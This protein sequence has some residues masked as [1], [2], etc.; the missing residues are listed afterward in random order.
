MKTFYVEVDTNDADYIGQLVEVSNEDAEKWMP[1][2]EKLKTSNHIVEFQNMEWSGNTI[3]TSHLVNAVEKI[4]V[5]N[6]RANYI[7]S[8]KRKWKHSRK[9]FGCGEVS[10]VSIQLHKSLR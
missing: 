2:I 10:M 6:L 9:H 8:A 3:T 7:I 1:L 5:K 4:S